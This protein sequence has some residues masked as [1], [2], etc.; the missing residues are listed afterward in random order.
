MDVVVPTCTLMPVDSVL[1]E[2]A[3]HDTDTDVLARKSRVSDVR[4]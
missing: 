4:R 2:A 1:D 3:F